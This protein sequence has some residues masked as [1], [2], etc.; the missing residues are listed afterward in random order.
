MAYMYAACFGDLEMVFQKNL[1]P[2]CLR[3]ALNWYC[4]W[5]QTAVNKKGRGIDQTRNAEPDWI[6]ILYNWSRLP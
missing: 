2:R 4:K 1:A 5:L 6:D 3:P